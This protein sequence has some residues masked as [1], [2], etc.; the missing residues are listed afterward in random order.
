[1]PWASD[2]VVK[3]R[4]WW[5]TAVASAYE[6]TVPNEGGKEKVWTGFAIHLLGSKA[7]PSTPKQSVKLKCQIWFEIV[8][9]LA[10]KCLDTSS[11]WDSR[12]MKCLAVSNL[13][14]I[15]AMDMTQF[16]YCYLLQ[17][18]CS[19]VPP[20]HKTGWSTLVFVKWLTSYLVWMTTNTDKAIIEMKSRVIFPNCELAWQLLFV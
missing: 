20:F 4:H 11:L 16:I 5:Y 15:T 9:K 3:W 13:P 8:K 2:V 10:E 17:Y 18:S 6:C 7:K 12:K 14:D 1:M 19:A